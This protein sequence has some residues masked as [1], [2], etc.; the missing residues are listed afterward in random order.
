MSFFTPEQLAAAH[1]ANLETFFGLT[2]KAFEGVEKL[3]ELNLA[4]VKETI[5]ESKDKADALLSVKDVQEL[6]SLQANLVQP[7]TEKLAAYSRHVYDITASAQSE[8]TKVAEA[9]I[10]DS[11]K[12]VS[13]L[14]DS[15]SKNAPAGSETAV[16]VVKSAIAAANNAYDSI[17]KAAKQA[18]EAAEANFAAASSTAVKATQAAVAKKK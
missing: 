6:L 7:L 14:V 13:A 3:V 8:F 10:A 11:S 2:H 1:K 5:A 4:V 15:A 12:K 17:N 18:V 9:T 16:A